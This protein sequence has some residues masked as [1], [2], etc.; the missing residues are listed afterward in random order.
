MST[1]KNLSPLKRLPCECEPS[2]NI[3]IWAIKQKERRNK[4]IIKILKAAKN[5]WCERLEV[6]FFSVLFPFRLL[7]AFSLSLVIGFSAS[8]ITDSMKAKK[9]SKTAKPSSY[10]LCLLHKFTSFYWR[11]FRV[12]SYARKKITLY[13]LSQYECRFVLSPRST[14]NARHNFFFFHITLSSVFVSWRFPPWIN[15][16]LIRIIFS[17]SCQISSSGCCDM[18]VLRRFTHNSLLAFFCFRQTRVIK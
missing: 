11:L 18:F 12:L 17:T 15:L 5:T 16:I 7:D 4:K 8:I 14:K 10:L 13:M 6:I 9:R 2:V 1:I 3:H